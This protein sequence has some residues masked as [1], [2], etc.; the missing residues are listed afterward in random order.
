MAAMPSAK[1]RRKKRRGRPSVVSRLSVGQIVAELN[2]RR[3]TLDGLRRQ[4]E[5]LAIQLESLDAQSAEIAS[6]VVVTP[7]SPRRGPDRPRG[8]GSGRGGNK[9]SLAAL[10]H[11]LLK[12]KTL[13]VPE[14]AVA[15][16]KAG[17]K[18]KSKKFRT[19]VGLAL[20]SHRKMFKR[21]AR[22]QYTSR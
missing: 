1:P 8:T 4:R 15:A 5:S 9:G 6:L 21:V 12:G 20:L 10:L 19:V 2:R 22:G 18:S 11:S 13:S 7:T 17:H 16:K 14:M 3:A